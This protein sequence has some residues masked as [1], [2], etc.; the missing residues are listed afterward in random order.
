MSKQIPKAPGVTFDDQAVHAR[1]LNRLSVRRVDSAYL[2]AGASTLTIDHDGAAYVLRITRR[3]KLILTKHL[4]GIASARADDNIGI[5]LAYLDG[6]NL[7]IKNT[8]VAESYY[9][10][11]VNEHLGVTADLQYMQEATSTVSFSVCASR[12]SFDEKFKRNEP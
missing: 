9:R 11:S 5:G 12:Q 10:W 6:G 7:S 8:S 1:P 2:F 3:N 4:K